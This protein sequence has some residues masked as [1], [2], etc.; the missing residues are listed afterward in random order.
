MAEG[1]RERSKSLFEVLK[2]KP[3]EIAVTFYGQAVG[4]TEACDFLVVVVER[5]S[6]HDRQQ[7]LPT[8][9]EHVCSRL[10]GAGLALPLR[11]ER[12]QWQWLW[13]RIR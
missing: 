13:P 10:L 4:D 5:D 8:T 12:E 11:S 1:W 3:G 7:L 9:R 2:I 6:N